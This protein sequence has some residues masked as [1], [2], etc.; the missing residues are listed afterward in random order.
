[1]KKYSLY[2]TLPID[3]Q[4]HNDAIWLY[5]SESLL[6]ALT[7][8]I[9]AKYMCAVFALLFRWHTIASKHIAQSRQVKVIHILLYANKPGTKIEKKWDHNKSDRE[10]VQT[11]FIISHFIIY[12]LRAHSLILCIITEKKTKKKK[13]ILNQNALRMIKINRKIWKR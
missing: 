4:L 7:N 12:R 3:Q 1:M 10:R 6:C 13:I 2:L 9:C 8:S 5:T 11:Y